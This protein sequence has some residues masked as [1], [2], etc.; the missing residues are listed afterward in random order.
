M[1]MRPMSVQGA[2][3]A[4]GKRSEFMT[5]H[6][7]VVSQKFWTLLKTR[8]PNGKGTNY[9]DSGASLQNDDAL[10]VDADD[11]LIVDAIVTNF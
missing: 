4:P 3:L 7:S 11:A 1:G 8:V 10:I 9:G 5:H 6:T 2:P